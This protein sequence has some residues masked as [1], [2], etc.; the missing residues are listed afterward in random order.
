MAMSEEEPS[1]AFQILSFKRYTESFKRLILIFF[2]M[3]HF[4]LL[5]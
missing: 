3:V 4:S 2:K 5:L 1:K